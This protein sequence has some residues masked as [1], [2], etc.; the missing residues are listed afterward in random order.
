MINN[1]PELDGNVRRQTLN[2]LE[3]A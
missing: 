3:K 2:W 1:S